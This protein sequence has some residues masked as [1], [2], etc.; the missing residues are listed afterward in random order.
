MELELLTHER[1]PNLNITEYPPPQRS[2]MRGQGRKSNVVKT[3]EKQLHGG[4]WGERKVPGLG[5]D[6]E[7]GPLG[8]GVSHSYGNRDL[9][10]FVLLTI[11]SLSS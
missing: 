11:L 5:L 1:C 4:N 9:N 2:A 7:N 3:P 6:A 8:S 10:G